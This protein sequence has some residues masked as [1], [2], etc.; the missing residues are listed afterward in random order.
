LPSAFSDRI[1]TDINHHGMKKQKRGFIRVLTLHCLVVF[2]CSSFAPSFPQDIFEYEKHL[3]AINKQIIELKKIISAEEKRESTMLTKVERI[4]LKK[5]LTRKEISL[6]NTQLRKTNQQIRNTQRRV[7]ELE[8]DLDAAR[9]DINKILVTLYKY[10]NISYFDLLFQVKD[11]QSLVSEHKHLGLLAA[12]Q[13]DLLSDFLVTLN[14]LQTAKEDLSSKKKETSLLLSK[15]QQKERTYNTQQNEYRDLIRQIEQNRNVYQETLNELDER[16]EILQSLIK[17]IARE[18]K[19]LS[20][21]PI[22]LYDRKGDIDWPV[23]GDVVSPFGE[24]VHPKFLTKTIN[25]GIEIASEDDVMVKAIQLARVAFAEFFT[26]YGKLIILD[27]GFK[28]H[29]LYAHCS[30]LLVK[31]GDVVETG[32]PIAV[33]GDIGSLKG[34]SL[35]FEIRVRT[36]AMNPLQWLKRR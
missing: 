21:S 12:S 34:K 8:A 32:Q 15:A 26:G 30:E 10:G 7:S 22:P 31:K 28:C 11:I 19:D 18:G 35:Y 17:R 14:E 25:N 29:S 36:E 4:G 33:V 23:S 5:E 3:H 16:A 20:F 6:F 27:H 13:N 1:K 9:K 24:Q 2:V